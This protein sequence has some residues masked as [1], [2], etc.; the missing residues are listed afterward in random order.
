MIPVLG[1]SDQARQ[2]NGRSIRPAIFERRSRLPVSA[3]C[4]V[5]NAVREI[6]S[7]LLG[8]PVN[9]AVC[10]PVIP[11][12]QAWPL[13]TGGA[14]M[15][16]ARGQLSD[17]AFIVRQ[18]DALALVSGIFC[19]DDAIETRTLSAIEGDVLQRAMASLAKALVSVCGLHD[20]CTLA[21]CSELSG[22]TTY[23]EL[24]FDAPFEATLG[25]ALSQEPVE[26]I[27]AMFDPS[28]LLDAEVEVSAQ[29][30]TGAVTAGTLLE[31]Q[32]GALLPMDT[33]LGNCA[34]LTVHGA[35]ISQGQC[36]VLE[37]RNAFLV[38]TL[39]ENH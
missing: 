23:F 19:E 24:F 29:F 30:A 38:Q 28:H 35:P 2:A 26:R 7:A 4:V 27:S 32:P 39:T 17:G 13:L 36:G 12:P 16:R 5:G 3:A 10:E 18:K 14:A 8:R 11:A 9:V 21:R 33:K 34:M 25:V 31:L 1:F 22:Y 20:E 37:Q 15:F 6:L